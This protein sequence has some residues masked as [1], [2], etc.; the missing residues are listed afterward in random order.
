MVKNRWFYNQTIFPVLTVSPLR[1]TS[2]WW[3]HRC[4]C[5]PGSKGVNIIFSFSLKW[6]FIFYQNYASSSNFQA[7]VLIQSENWMPFYLTLIILICPKYNYLTPWWYSQPFLE[8][9][10]LLWFSWH[11]PPF[12]LPSDVMIVPVT[13]ER[14]W[15]VAAIVP[16]S[17]NSQL[18]I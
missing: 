13:A 17:D 14:I 9:E 11:P 6:L 1:E 15:H 3:T 8:S 5:V 18:V 12:C 2:P 16:S 10:K 7:A 4:L